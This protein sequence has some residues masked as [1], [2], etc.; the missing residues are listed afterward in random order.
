MKLPT[1]RNA[2]K[3]KLVIIA[4]F[5]SV[6]FTATP[7]RADACSCVA[8]KLTDQLANST[9]IFAGKMT[10]FERTKADDIN[11]DVRFTF[12]LERT[13][14][15]ESADVMTVWT[16]GNSAACGSN[17]E[18]G[19]SYV[20]FATTGDKG[21]RTGL[22]SGNT[23]ATPGFLAEIDAAMGTPT[24]PP[25]QEPPPSDPPPSDPPPSDPPPSDPPP[26]GTPPPVAKGNPACGGCASS[27]NNG[28]LGGLLWIGLVLV[29]A[30][31]R[32]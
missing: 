7:Q 5:S 22:C 21:L 17:F 15:G 23:I 1:S 26:N 14:K 31:R 18:K 8:P 13:F 25:P 27:A 3:F 19:K 30:R 16:G 20:V 32:L 4:A 29:F 12:D 28:A 6:V 10:A 11:S 2:I 9:T 24:T